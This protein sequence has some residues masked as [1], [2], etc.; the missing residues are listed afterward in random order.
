M[1]LAR[2]SPAAPALLPFVTFG[3]YYVYWHF[4][5]NRELSDLGRARGIRGLGKSPEL[6]LLAVTLGWLLIVPPLV[7]HVQTTRRIK[8]AQRGVGLSP[9]SSLLAIFLGFFFWPA[10]PAYIQSELNGLWTVVAGVPGYTQPAPHWAPPQIAPQ[11][12]APQL[13]AAAPP[14]APTRGAL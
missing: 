14:Q 4:A 11:A 5:V 8:R 7:S 13:V 3:V 1:Q 12:L 6:S 10:R 9:L 2:R